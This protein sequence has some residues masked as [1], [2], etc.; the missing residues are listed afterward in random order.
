ME[1]EA[2]IQIHKNQPDLSNISWDDFPA[3]LQEAGLHFMHDWQENLPTRHLRELSG[4]DDMSVTDLLAYANGVEQ[5]PF[6]IQE[7]YSYSEWAVVSYKA[8][9]GEEYQITL[10]KSYDKNIGY[11]HRQVLTIEKGGIEIPEDDPIWEEVKR[12]VEQ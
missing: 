11:E 6:T 5:E 4:F 12:A 3:A 1:F 7:V 10:T 8:R 2:F 9:D